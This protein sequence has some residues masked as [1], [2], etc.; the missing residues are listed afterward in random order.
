MQS[1]FALEW[2][3]IMEEAKKGVL[4]GKEKDKLRNKFYKQYKNMGKAMNKKMKKYYR[5]VKKC[6]CRKGIIFILAGFTLSGVAAGLCILS[7]NCLGTGLA[8]LGIGLL[9]AGFFLLHIYKRHD[10]HY[11]NNL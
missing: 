1:W 5:L 6:F 2:S 11:L 3:G 7:I 10:E 8:G 4:S 9:V